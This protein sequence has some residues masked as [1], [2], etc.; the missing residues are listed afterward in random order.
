MLPVNVYIRKFKNRFSTSDTQSPKI[1][2]WN[3]FGLT[4]AQNFG[5][6]LG[7]VLLN[8]IFKIQY[9]YADIEDCDIITIGSILNFVNDVENILQIDHPIHV[10]GSGLIEPVNGPFVQNLNYSAV[11]G[12]LTA[13]LLNIRNV[14]L[15]DPGLLCSLVYKKS[16]NTRKKICIIPHH[17]EID[18]P[19]FKSI[20]DNEHLT[21]VSPLAEPDDIVPV[22]ASSSLVLSSSLHGLIVADSFS[23]PNARL[24]A[25]DRLKGGDFKFNDYY[26]ALSK[27]PLQFEVSNNKDLEKII[28]Q[29]I[30]CYTPI[31]NLKD[32]QNGLL[33]AFPT[34][35]N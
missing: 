27:H 2:W 25:S 19:F 30:K 12:H 7:P 35:I 6:K 33:K 11:R 34:S 14:Q 31:D 23:I 9:T 10:W 16:H 4:G 22:I 3:P 17:E 15:G 20:Q 8:K 24:H 29:T 18:L 28:K 5:D 21:V 13:D 32:L 26:S 1:Y